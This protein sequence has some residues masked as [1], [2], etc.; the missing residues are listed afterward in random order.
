MQSKER[1]EFL[2]ERRQATSFP[3]IIIMTGLI[4]FMQRLPERWIVIQNRFDAGIPA[5][6]SEMELA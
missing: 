6:P 4:D 5:R 2:H 3:S 1:A